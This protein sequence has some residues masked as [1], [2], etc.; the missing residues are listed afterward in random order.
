[1]S[2]GGE[3][4]G[5]NQSPFPSVVPR[6]ERQ[7]HSGAQLTDAAR[8]QADWLVLRLELVDADGFQEGVGPLT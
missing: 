8:S 1:M 5:A 6:K 4:K 7:H 2:N 3:G